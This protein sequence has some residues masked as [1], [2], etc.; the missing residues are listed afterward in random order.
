MTKEQMNEL[1]SDI[2]AMYAEPYGILAARASKKVTLR[3]ME[4]S[5]EETITNCPYCNYA[6][7]RRILI[8]CGTILEENKDE[9]TLCGIIMSG[10]LNM[11][12]AIVAIAIS[13]DGIHIKAVAKEGLI[14]QHTA[15]KA[16][17]IFKSF[18]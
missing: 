17:A 15:Q 11:N 2:V 13:D 8:E 14:K 9:G 7:A 3:L 1:L 10:S 6:L 18:L 16:I 12:P 4:S 5:V